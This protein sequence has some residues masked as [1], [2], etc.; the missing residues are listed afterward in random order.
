MWPSNLN[1]VLQKKDIVFLTNRNASEYLISICE[2]LFILKKSR[3]VRLDEFW[4][5]TRTK[6]IKTYIHNHEMVTLPGNERDIIEMVYCRVR[7]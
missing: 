3:L 7:C 2:S 5:Y 6:E 1:P 4:V